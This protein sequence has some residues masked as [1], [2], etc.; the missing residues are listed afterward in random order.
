MIAS[1]HGGAVM[2]GNGMKQ[3]VTITAAQASTLLMISQQRVRQLVR[4]GYIPRTERDAYPLVGVVQGYLR[5]LRDDERRSSRSASAANLNDAR[6]Q[7]IERRSA[8]REAALVDV[9]E[10]RGLYSDLTGEIV[11][12][13]AALPA[14]CS[15][16]PATRNAI[17]T[18]CDAIQ[19]AVRAKAGQWR[20]GVLLGR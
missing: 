3:A 7:E 16:D 14:R 19:S 11:K 20:G 5:F 9:D 17:A 10:A 15:K 8:E 12:T 2:A 18:Q 4:D 1:V 6:R 13:L